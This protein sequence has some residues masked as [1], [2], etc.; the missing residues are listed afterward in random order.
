[1]NVCVDRDYFL[2]SAQYGYYE[3][4]SIPQGATNVLVKDKSPNF[5]GQYGRQTIYLKVSFMYEKR[6]KLF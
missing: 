1:M 2:S 5:L 3:V 6:Y 4:A